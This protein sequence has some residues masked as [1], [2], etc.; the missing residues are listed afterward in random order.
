MQRTLSVGKPALWLVVVAAIPLLLQ[1]YYLALGSTIGINALLAMGLILVIG[2]AGQFSL[3]M[4]AFYGIGAY[5]SALL[6]V[7]VGWPATLALAVSAL[8]AAGIAYAI[9]GAIF[10]LRGHFLAMGTLA[11]T[12][13]FF[14]LVTNLTVTGGSSGFGGVPFFSVFGF[15]FET[16]QQQF[17]L[18]WTILGICLWG[19]LRIAKGREGRALLAVRGQEAAA[20]S[21][22]IHVTWSKT[23]IF[24]ASAAI[25][26]I[27]GSLY[28]HQLLYVNPP[29]F[30]LLTA[31]DILVIA[32]LGGL[33][34]PWGAIVGALCLEVLRQFIEAVLPGI[35]GSGSVGAGQTLALGLILVLI[36]VLR[37][38][39][40][41]GLVGAGA[42]RLA[43][44]RTAKSGELDEE[45]LTRPT[46][47]SDRLR[48]ASREEPTMD[49][50][51]LSAQGI[52]KTFGGVVALQDVDLEIYPGEVLAVIGPNGAGK[53]TLVNVLSGNLPPTRGRVH[54]GEKDV[55]GKPSHVVSGKGLARTFQTPSLF[56]GM[57]VRDNVLVGAHLRGSVGLLR[58][59][60]PTVGAVHEERRLAASVE[61]VLEALGLGNLADIDATQLSLGQQ[62]MVELARALVMRPH[63]LLLDEPCAGLARV[64]KQALSETL[65]TLRD[66][67]L[68]LLLIEHDMEFVMGLADRVHVLNFG[69]TLRTGT[70]AEVQQDSAV[71]DAYLGVA[72][73]QDEVD[74]D[75][76]ATNAGS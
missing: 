39:G 45:D 13:M 57:S 36:L 71:I 41:V 8:V 67:G 64:E 24:A 38:D 11:L 53:S 47:D 56:R 28:A 27:A 61:D 43:R 3:A 21:C 30:G 20:A 58:S 62:K 49:G 55:T 26:S 18:N 66:A 6:T 51:L 52:G 54:V 46:I 2:Y 23:R 34:S 37:P 4:A 50:R 63:L 35:F 5:G 1:D 12:E 14:L 73:S 59:A 65:A 60:V 72:E 70:P 48:E 32:V 74:V 22:G 76:S 10:R 29:P 33:R 75:R 15:V 9:G 40:L 19:S 25:G 7:N 68:A 69:K 42:R 31:I 17:W 44:S 16:A